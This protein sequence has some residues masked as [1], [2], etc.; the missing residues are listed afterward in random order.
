MSFFAVKFVLQT[1]AMAMS[2]GQWV[3][4]I[5]NKYFIHADLE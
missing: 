4:N 2:G 5:T 1:C 3:I